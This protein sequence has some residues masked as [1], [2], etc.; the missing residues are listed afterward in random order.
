MTD[1]SA[2]RKIHLAIGIQEG[3]SQL[4]PGPPES[5]EPDRFSC[6]PRDQSSFVYFA[7]KVSLS[8]RMNSSYYNY[9]LFDRPQDA[10]QSL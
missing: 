4:F 2:N 3:N 5:L 6:C 7:F 10:L 1:P 9:N 8:N